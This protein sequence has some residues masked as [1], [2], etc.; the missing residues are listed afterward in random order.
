MKRWVIG[1]AVVAVALVVAQA[2]V[3]VSGALVQMRAGAD[4]LTAR[5]PERP[6][7]AQDADRTGPPTSRKPTTEVEAINT[8]VVP[9]AAPFLPTAPPPA[10]RD[11]TTTLSEAIER[12]P[13]IAETLDDPDPTVRDSVRRFLSDSLE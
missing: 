2:A 1:I 5:H 6:V 13:E 11:Q 3:R 12:S 8:H 7:L 10:V 4:S 9:E